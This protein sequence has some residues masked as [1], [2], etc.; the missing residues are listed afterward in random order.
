MIFYLFIFSN[1]AQVVIQLELKIMSTWT[2]CVLLVE[3]S[4]PH[5][6]S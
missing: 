3:I 4:G 5:E 6:F 1:F 2:E